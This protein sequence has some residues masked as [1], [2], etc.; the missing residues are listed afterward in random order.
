MRVLGIILLGL[1]IFLAWHSKWFH[2]ET[3]LSRYPQIR[4]M[5]TTCKY[6][7]IRRSKSSRTRQIVLITGNG[8][9][10]MEDEVWRKHFDGPSLAAALSRGGIVRAWVHPDYPFVLRGIM[11]GAVDI[12]P[13]WGLDYDQRDMRVGIFVDSVF[14][15]TGLYLIS[16]RRRII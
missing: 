9:Y 3:N 4:L 5:Y 1:A 16:R 8:R 7:E 6:E 13:E 2:A 15:L 11:G 14:A 10:V 12:P